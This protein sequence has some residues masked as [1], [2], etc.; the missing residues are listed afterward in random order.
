MKIIYLITVISTVALFNHSN[1]KELKTWEEMPTT[2]NFGDVKGVP[3]EIENISN[4]MEAGGYVSE[5]EMMF[6]SEY[7][8]KETE[9]WNRWVSSL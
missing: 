5:A 7:I 1:K 3:K 4:R 9:A 2:E 8:D 6:I